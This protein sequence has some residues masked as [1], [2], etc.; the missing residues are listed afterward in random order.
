MS[1][2][3]R[4]FIQTITVVTLLGLT[5]SACGKT[6]PTSTIPATTIPT[7]VQATATAIPPKT[8]VVCL[9]YEPTSLY[10]Y[11]D[12]SRAM[13]SVL[14]AIYDGPIDT[15]N[16][17]AEPVIL[18]ALPTIENGGVT[19]SSIP[20]TAGDEVANVEGDLVALARGVKVF[21]AGCTSLNCA[22]EWDGTSELSVS[23]MSAR[24]K[25]K[26]G[27]TWSDGETLSAEDSVFSYTVAADPAS[28]VS[29]TLIKRTAAY[30][31]VDAQTVLWTGIPGYLTTNPSAFFWIP[32]PNHVLGTMTADQM[33]SADET[34]KA[35][36][37]WGP[38]AV[39]EW[40]A[41]D[42]I[43]LVKN[44]R[45]FRAS[46]GFPKFDVLVFRF[47]PGLTETDLSPLVSGECDIMETSVGLETQIQSLRELENAGETKLFFGQGPEW[48]L[49]N[50]GIKPASYD[51][52]YNPYLDRQDFFGDLRTRQAFA[53]CVDR[54]M[55]IKDVM[56]SRSQIPAS[57]LPVEHPYA[58]AG[59]T[60]IP[61]DAAYGSSLLEQV[62][63]VD[64][65]NDP[66]T[67]R[68]A[69]GVEGVKDGTKFSVTYN[70]T[71]STLHNSVSAIVVSSLA[72]CGV[73]VTVTNLEV[74]DMF[75]PGPDGVVFG[76]AFDL[77]ELAWSTGRQP[78]CF[79]YSSNEI[80]TAKNSWVGTKYGGV[81]L[82][83]F[84]NEDYDAACS[85]QL[86]AGLNV[87]A[88]N[89]DNQFT[90]QIFNAELPVLPLFYHL[91]V[92]AARTDLCGVSLDVSSRSGI[93]NLETFDLSATGNC[94]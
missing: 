60:F 87:E 57:Y 5:L 90:Q 25:I 45:Y 80:P 54:E 76:R 50:F 11:K 7:E 8:L 73:E 15:T 75:A 39:D 72:E 88:F 85:R 21:P 63:W 49:V 9:G 6:T 3:C 33:N 67:P 51:D 58:V 30:V 91:K 70:V 40:T 27:I 41:G 34:N 4:R 38:Y 69:S 86:S 46:E 94:Q 82:T 44:E 64:N 16:F 68:V 18:D 31:A 81:N 89:A 78:P 24:F 12:S 13:W 32:L 77:A 48:E 71:Q 56:F 37:G 43:R 83:G 92:M 79:L 10:L 47:T 19:L 36:L 65:D 20:V 1:F 52:V 74:T 53:S 28:K 2:S 66:A 42:H 62:G 55:I 14:E 17:Q 35:P 29:K 22:I 93:K 84:S 61:H 23:Q 59:L 26:P